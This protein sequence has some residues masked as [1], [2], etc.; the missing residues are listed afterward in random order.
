MAAQ[1]A[2]A[3]AIIYF[4][5]LIAVGM[6]A[7]LAIDRWMRSKDLDLSEIQSQAG[8]NRESVA[9]FC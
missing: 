6:V 9:S 3:T 7:K 8:P 5:S 4:G 2:L 1:H